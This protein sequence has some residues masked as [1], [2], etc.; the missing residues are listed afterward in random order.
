MLL[1][2]TLLAGC[3]V[4]KG[5]LVEE[6]PAEYCDTLQ[7]TYVDTCKTIVDTYC[8]VAGCHNNAATIGDF[9]TYAGMS[10]QGVLEGDEQGLGGRIISATNPM[11][12]SGLLPDTIRRV[13]ECWARNGYPEEL[14]P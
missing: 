9:S 4:D 5:E 1:S 6:T 14:T 11:P 2:L 10:D 3:L 13:L 12:P 8:A 7:A